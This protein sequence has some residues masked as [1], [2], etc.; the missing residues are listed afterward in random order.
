VQPAALIAAAVVAQLLHGQ[1]QQLD[2]GE[3]L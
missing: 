1:A 2:P 3:I